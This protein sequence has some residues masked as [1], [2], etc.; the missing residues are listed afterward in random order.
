[1]VPLLAAFAAGQVHEG[2]L[3][4][5]IDRPKD[6]I[7]LAEGGGLPLLHPCRPGFHHMQTKGQKIVGDFC[8]VRYCGDQSWSPS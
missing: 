3:G 1:M 5:R 2:T 6:I 4:E 8:P 7:T